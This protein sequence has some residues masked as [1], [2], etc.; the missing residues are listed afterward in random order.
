MTALITLV[1]TENV[2]VRMATIAKSVVLRRL[3]LSIV[4]TM[5]LNVRP[6]VPTV[7]VLA[8]WEQYVIL[9]VFLVL[10]M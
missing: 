4:L 8:V 6:S 10:V 2:F 3:V 1:Q 9:D 5:A 7:T